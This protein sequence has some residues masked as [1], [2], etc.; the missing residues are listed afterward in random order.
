MFTMGG[1]HKKKKI[2]VFFVASI[3]LGYL[4]GCSNDEKTAVSSSGISPYVMGLSAV[5][6]GSSLPADGSSQ[7]T[8]LAEV[9][10][11]AGK[12]VDGVT[13]TLSAS[14]GTL[15]SSD[16]TSST[17][18][19]SAA[20]SLTLTTSNGVATAYFTAGQAAG[21]A[22]INA[23]AENARATVKIVLATFGS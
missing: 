13:V 4:A 6:G 17:S 1:F 21:A 16:S 10:D 7:A 18:S 15:S 5:Y 23:T 8:I 11:S 12:Y 9:W 19:G 2:A 22:Y 20:S 3:F 14:R